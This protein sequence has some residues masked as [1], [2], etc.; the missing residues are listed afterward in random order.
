MSDRIKNVAVLGVTLLLC[1]LVAEV[2]LRF[3]APQRVPRFPAGL[4]VAD[5]L[6]RY[7][8]TPNFRGVASTGEY[9]TK[10]K[11]D[12]LGLREDRDYGA[13]PARTQ[14][15]LALGDS[16]TMGVGVES[17]DSFP[18]V[19]ERVLQEGA[20]VSPIEV[21]N[22]GVP[23]YNTRQERLYL[24]GDGLALQPDLVLLNV[25]VGNDIHDNLKEDRVKVVDGY[26]VDDSD[27]GGLLPNK[28]RVALSGSHLY[29]LLWPLQRRLRDSTFADEERRAVQA[30]LS[31]YERRPDQQVEAMWTATWTE[32]ARAKELVEAHGLRLAVVVIPELRQVDPIIWQTL[33]RSDESTY[34]RDVPNRRIVDYCTAEGI[35][36]LDLL[37]TFLAAEH[38]RENYFVVDNHWTVKGNKVAARAIRDF[39]A[40]RDLVPAASAP[41]VAERARAAQ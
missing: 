3:V 8:L 32:M 21:I 23:G 11:T 1:T 35:P 15:V 17:A 6:L 9:R 2:G 40:A 33:T 41:K 12:T 5:P 36:V 39:L 29:Q 7:R 38:P 22:A 28:V 34:G 20:S 18:K 24:A 27:S 30:Y 37:P 13:K 25:F 10:L 4:F 19:L 14:R 31:I 16:F 26:L